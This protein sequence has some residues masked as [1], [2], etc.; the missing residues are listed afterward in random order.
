M[1]ALV[2][3]IIPTYNR[4]HFIGET[5]DSIIAQT[6][7]NWECIVVD[8]GS[9]DYTEELV[10]LYTQKDTRIKYHHRPANWKKGANVCRNYGFERSKGEYLIWF[11]SDDLMT[12]NHIGFKVTTIKSKNLDFIV[13]KTQNFSHG[14]LLEPYIYEKKKYGITSSDFILLKIHWYTYD[15]MLK[16]KI[17][18]KIEWNKHMKSWQDYNFFCKMLLI[19]KNGDYLDEVLTHRRLHSQSIQKSLNKT[20]GN[21]NK[22]M[23]DN[24]VLTYQDISERTDVK[25]QKQLLFGMMNLCFEI[26]KVRNKPSRVREVSILIKKEFGLKSTF[27]FQLALITA[28][29]TGK[30]HYF[31]DKAKKR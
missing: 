8:D 6:Y 10:G 14:K 9:I 13:A 23:L 5:L 26:S 15:V 30:G 12:P 25:T 16:R 7:E 2:S 17:A 4:A 1:K 27:Y 3:I 22:E 20:R 21:F 24:R 29:I 18:E 28:K 11:D 19:T 31:L